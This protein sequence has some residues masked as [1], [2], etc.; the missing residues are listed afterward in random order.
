MHVVVW[1]AGYPHAT[2]AT[3][4]PIF[5]LQNDCFCGDPVSVLAAQTSTSFDDKPSLL[6]AGCG[7]GTIRI[8]HVST[9]RLAYNLQ[10]SSSQVGDLFCDT[11]VAYITRQ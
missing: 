6:A 8:F 9:G 10:S 2:A 11:Y 3:L 1:V 4:T 5:V 7:D